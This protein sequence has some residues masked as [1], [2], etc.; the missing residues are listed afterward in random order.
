M[1]INIYISSNPTK[2]N[3]ILSI[4][5][6]ECILITC[7]HARIQSE[8]TKGAD[9]SGSIGIVTSVALASMFGWIYLVAY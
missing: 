3:W 9:R 4:I 7:N 5:Y 1:V 2:L 8:E 6:S